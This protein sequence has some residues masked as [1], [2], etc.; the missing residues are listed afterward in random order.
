[1]KACVVGSGRRADSTMKIF[2]ALKKSNGFV[3]SLPETCPPDAWCLAP[4]NWQI[5]ETKVVS[6][7]PGIEELMIKEKGQEI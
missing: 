4:P 6:Q 3:F 5:N 2:S 1:M 7:I